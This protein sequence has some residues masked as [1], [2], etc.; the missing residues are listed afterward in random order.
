MPDASS[1]AAISAGGIALAR[2]TTGSATE[3][4]TT[5]DAGPP[6]IGPPSSTRATASPS[7]EAISAASRASASSDRLA[8]V[9]RKGWSSVEW[10][11]VSL[12]VR[13]VG[14]FGD[15]AFKAGWGEQR[16]CERDMTHP[17]VLAIGVLGAV[18]LILGRVYL[19]HT[20][21]GRL[22]ATVTYGSR[23]L[24]WLWRMTP[25]TSPALG[26]VLLVFSSLELWPRPLGVFVAAVALSLF[27]L[28]VVLSY[29][30]PPPFM[31]AWMRAEIEQAA[32]HA[33]SHVGST[34]YGSGC[35]P[36]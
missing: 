24:P 27:A 16:T 7:R 34:V 21:R 15:E 29:R 36:R 11:A 5:V 20:E 12:A 9:A 28:I 17:A 22:Q 14:D 26:V 33:P 1:P 13:S 18:V 23:E 25:V 10:L 32:S 4:S 30:Y 19:D 35:L 6:R 3:Q 31:A 8:E 2:S